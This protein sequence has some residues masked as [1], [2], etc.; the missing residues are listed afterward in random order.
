ML[1]TLFQCTKSEYSEFQLSWKLFKKAFLDNGRIVDTGNKKISHSEGQGYG[2]LFAV[3]ANDQKSFDDIWHWTQQVLQR[4]D[5]LF[6]WQYTPCSTQDRLC[7]QDQN[8]A[9]DGDILIAWALFIAAEKWKNNEYEDHALDVLATIKK[10]LIVKQFN[11]LL[12]LPGEY[13]FQ[14]TKEATEVNLSYWV[15]PALNKFSQVTHDK[16]WGDLYISGI[17]LLKTAQF[18]EWQLPP[19]WLIVSK[20]GLRINGAQSSDYGYNAS[21]IPI[22]LMLAGDKTEKLISPFLNFWQQDNVPA[23][24]NLQT[25][26]IADYTY[27]SGMEAIAVA[28]KQLITKQK[29]QDIPAVKYETDYYSASLILLA[30]LSLL[31]REL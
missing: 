24:I 12:L 5:K 22:Y 27:S 7:I 4:N 8:N 26:N 9:T 16:V 14:P 1:L 3:S 13:G 6:S 17:S 23:T 25:E 2:M 18:S 28:T 15:F 20:E 31:E 21:R 11:H 10:K 29:K 30:Q 19:D